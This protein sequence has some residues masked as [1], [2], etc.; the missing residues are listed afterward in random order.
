MNGNGSSKG[1]NLKRFLRTSSPHQYLRSL[2][3]AIC[4]SVVPITAAP[5]VEG[6]AAPPPADTSKQPARGREG[7][8]PVQPRTGAP[9]PPLAAEPSV[10]DLGF[11][12]P[13]TAGEGTVQIRNT[14][15]TPL[16]ITGVQP[17]CKCTTPNDL[18]GKVIEPGKSIEMKLKLDGAP[19]V[20]PRNSSVKIMV[21]GF[22]RALDIPVRAEVTL[23][24]RCVPPY[25]NAVEGKNLIGRLVLESIDG[26]PF[27]ILS[28]SGAQMVI[29]YGDGSED[30]PRASWVVTYDVTGTAEGAALPPYLLFETD[31]A[32]AGVVDVRVRS[33]RA[34]QKPKIPVIEQRLNL[35]RVAAGTSGTATFVFKLKDMKVDSVT[36]TSPDATVE[37]AA[38][39]PGAEDG[40]A[41]S[42]RIT[43]RAGI[44]G[45]ITVPIAVRAGPRA[46]DVEAVLSVR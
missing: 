5:P 39:A 11:L 24:V 6:Q 8:T 31:A 36:T 28:M 44:S 21:D 12:A 34:P 23:P 13:N 7:A 14:G 26:K 2:A 1:F 35:G 38:T 16:T 4:C 29:Q 37:L 17:S 46:A 33:T 30:A 27:K 20:G 40:T 32:G 42:V 9:A 45:I 25:V 19:A 10:A 43:P 41:V 18:V 15:S 22:T 3:A